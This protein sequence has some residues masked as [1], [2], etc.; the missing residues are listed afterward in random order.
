M[1]SAWE[2]EMKIRQALSVALVAVILGVMS[3]WAQE[4][5]K[6]PQ[7]AGK[8][9]AAEEPRFKF[10]VIADLW[11]RRSADSTVFEEAVREIN[12]IDPDFTISVGDLVDGYVTEP[13][14]IK[15]QWDAFDADIRKLKRP[16]YYAYGNHDAMNPEMI[17][18]IRKRYGSSYYSFNCKNC[19]FI[20][21]FT[22]SHGAEGRLVG[23]DAD[24]AQVAWLAKDLADSRGAVHTFV[25]LHRPWPGPKV[26]DLFKGRPTTVFAGHLHEYQEFRKDGLNYHVLGTTGGAISGDIYSG[27]LYHYM[28]VTVSA[29]EV[30]PAVVRVGAIV[31]DTFLSTERRTRIAD[32][33]R[34]L[35]AL[36]LKV[37]KGAGRIDQTLDVKIPNPLPSAIRGSCE[38]LVPEGSGWSVT[39]KQA[40]FTVEAESESRLTFRLTVKGDP[41]A[42]ER[43]FLPQIRIL[44]RG[45]RALTAPSPKVAGLDLLYN[46]TTTLSM[47]R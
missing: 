21:L 36:S 4:T 25:F 5:N 35:S 12:L 2:E 37:P 38:W 19:H 45:G 43:G 11:A 20:V 22:E 26:M 7:Y 14:L 42:A 3:V 47:E 15:A 9:A 18:V 30:S 31:P 23:I 32:A 44:A 17:E 1:N 8:S 34:A 39:P 10:A 40:E 29:N 16:F 33:R 6:A 41:F 27:G 46:I 24:D 13:D 28:L